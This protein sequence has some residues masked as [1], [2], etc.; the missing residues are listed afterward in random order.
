MDINFYIVYYKR[1]KHK[2]RRE[3][4]IQAIKK[5]WRKDEIEY[6]ITKYPELIEYFI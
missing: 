2:K 4:W 1:L 5:Y 3:A 6:F